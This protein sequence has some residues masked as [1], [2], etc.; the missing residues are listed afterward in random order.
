MSLTSYQLLSP[1]TLLLILF[2][3][4][5]G[6][7]PLCYVPPGYE[8]GEMTTSLL[9][10]V[11][12]FVYGASLYYLPHFIGIQF[13]FSTQIPAIRLLTSTSSNLHQYLYMRCSGSPS[14]NSSYCDTRLPHY[15][16][17]LKRTLHCNPQKNW[18]R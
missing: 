5:V 1:R 7:E 6:F 15:V 10:D 13:L 12:E 11:K 17:H 18:E 9:R 3:A 14:T 16:G 2:V 8:P 4:E